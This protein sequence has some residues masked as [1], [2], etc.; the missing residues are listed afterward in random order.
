MA[1]GLLSG[2]MITT[3]SITGAVIDASGHSI[4]GEKI[5]LVSD[6]TAQL[7]TALTGEEG[8]FNMQAV[9]P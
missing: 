2:K 1:C 7:R 3:G 8:V 5:T 6:R 9:Q 4:A